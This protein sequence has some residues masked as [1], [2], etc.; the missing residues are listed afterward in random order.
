MMT[1]VPAA[2]TASL[3]GGA[4]K[5]FDTPNGQKKFARY[6]VMDMPVI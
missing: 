2:T 6:S 5:D 3:S 1:G 4:R